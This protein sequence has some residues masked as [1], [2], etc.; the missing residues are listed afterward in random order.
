MAAWGRTEGALPCAAVPRSSL[1]FP[2]PTPLRAPL[3]T[4]LPPLLSP[5]HKAEHLLL[6]ARIPAR[7]AP[8]RP[9]L[10]GPLA[11]MGCSSWSQLTHLLPSFRESVALSDGARR[12]QDGASF[13]AVHQAG[14]KMPSVDGHCWVSQ[15]GV[16]T[17]RTTTAVEVRSIAARNVCCEERKLWSLAL[18]QLL[19]AGRGHRLCA[20]VHRQHL[21]SLLSAPMRTLRDPGCPCRWSGRGSGTGLCGRQGGWRGGQ[22]SPRTEPSPTGKRASVAYSR[23]G[24]LLGPGQAM[25]GPSSEGGIG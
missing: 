2:P 17:S 6:N 15:T 1:C 25:P 18:A 22:G 21:W 8:G 20:R 7:T 13:T 24:W 9:R 4:L 12:C 19:G 14:G 11:Q 3:L 10:G 23:A 16:W 5:A